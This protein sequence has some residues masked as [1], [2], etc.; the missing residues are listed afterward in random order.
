MSYVLE[1]LKSYGNEALRSCVVEGPKS[2][3]RRV[4]SRGM[5]EVK[6]VV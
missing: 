3:E 6:A 1:A 2:C 4:W 5:E